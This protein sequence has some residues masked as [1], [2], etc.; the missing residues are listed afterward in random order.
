MYYD[1]P[2]DAEPQSAAYAA[3]HEQEENFGDAQSQ[4]DADAAAHEEE[5]AESNDPSEIKELA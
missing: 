3:A 2:G 4:L 1:V 5:V